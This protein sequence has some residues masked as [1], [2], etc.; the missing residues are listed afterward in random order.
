MPGGK[1]V[2][3]LFPPEGR[4]EA[5]MAWRGAWEEALEDRERPHLRLAGD[6]RETDVE[7]LFEQAKKAPKKPKEAAQE[8]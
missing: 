5:E 7:D 6:P 4:Y 8:G 2:A 3:S 1:A